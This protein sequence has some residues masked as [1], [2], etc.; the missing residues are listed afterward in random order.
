MRACRF[1]AAS[2]SRPSSAAWNAVTIVLDRDLAEVAAEGLREPPRVGARALG[3]VARRHRD[4][5]HALRPERVDRERRD[6]RRVDA[7]REAEHDVAEAVLAHVVAQREHERAPHLL[8]LR[9]E[10]GDLAAEGLG[11]APPPSRAR[12]ARARARPRA[13]GRA[14]GVDVAQAPADRLARVEID[15]EQRLLE[16][17]A[18]ARTSPSSSSTTE[19]PSKSSSSWPPT[20]LQNARR[21]SCRGRASTSISSRASALPT[22][23]GEA[24][25]LTSSS[26]PASARSVAGGPGCQTSSQMVGPIRTSPSRSST[27]FA[28]GREVPVFVEDAVIREIA[29]SGRAP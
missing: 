18:R 8:E 3:G 5:V 15:D 25:M 16:P 24:E 6:E 14:S 19:W 26:A 29:A 7:A 23:Y 22:W 9:L 17:G 13:R 2:P 10:R 4:A 28:P 21:R 1:S 20:R 12:R 27:S 11:A